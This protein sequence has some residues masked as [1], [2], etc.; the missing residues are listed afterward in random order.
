MSRRGGRI[1][2]VHVIRY[3]LGL[4]TAL[5]F[6]LSNP[7]SPAVSP[8]PPGPAP[9]PVS[10][11]RILPPP[12]LPVPVRAG[13]APVNGIQMYYAEYGSGDPIL[14]I[15]IGMAA[16]DMWS[17]EVPLLDRTHTVILAD[18]RGH[19]RS[20]RTSEPLTYGLLASDYLALLDYLKIKKVALVGA[21]D[22]AIIGLDI[23]IHHPD[24]L[25]RLFAQ[26]AN[27]TLDG[28]FSD[29]A[30]PTASNAA[31]ALWQSEYKALSRTPGE[32]A[33]F[34]AAMKRMWD[35]EPDYTTAQLASI[36]V[37]TAI[38]IC[39]HDEWVKPEHASYLARTVPGART[40]VLH[41]VSHYAALQDPAA[42][43]QAIL[44]FV[45]Q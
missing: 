31:T 35:S 6:T 29:A 13:Y 27:A 44:A 2:D 25:T 32:Y 34:H 19:G 9:T 33:A 3:L 18:T 20:T 15:A 14:L 36:P 21:S 12:P 42:Y 1:G 38:V 40:I 10:W 7:P 22:G 16:S 5:A 23:A 28:V 24:R 30:D 39:D 8:S 37:A 26:G 41:G 17:A 43:A 11:Q 4:A 45:G